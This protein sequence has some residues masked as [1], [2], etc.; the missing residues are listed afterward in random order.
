M[1]STHTV[2]LDP[3]KKGI[4]S[5]FMQVTQG[6]VYESKEMLRESEIGYRDDCVVRHGFSDFGLECEAPRRRVTTSL[7]SHGGRVIILSHSSS[8]RATPGIV[9]DVN[10]RGVIK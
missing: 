7:N 8:S 6:R 5:I 10:L 9:S 4:A 2:C 3:L 1:Y